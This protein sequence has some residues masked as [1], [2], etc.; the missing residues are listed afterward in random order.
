MD[1]E[2]KVPENGSE[3][4]EEKTDLSTDQQEPETPNEAVEPQAEEPELEMASDDAPVDPPVNE[5]EPSEPNADAPAIE[6][7]VD[8]IVA[9]EQATPEVAESQTDTPI[10]EQPVNAE[11]ALS[12]QIVNNADHKAH[13]KKLHLAI[14]ALLLVIIVGMV[15]YLLAGKSSSPSNASTI[16]AS[17]QAITDQANKSNTERE[18]DIQA[19]GAGIIGY[20]TNNSDTLPQET[21]SSTNGTTLNLCGAGCTEG[22]TNKASVKLSYYKADNVVFESYSASLKVSNADAVYIVD[23]ATC[24]NNTLAPGNGTKTAAIVYGLQQDA[25]ISNVLQQCKQVSLST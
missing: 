4:D 3:S 13:N 22:T 8:A 17:P 19:I 1:S 21:N 23:E 11:P 10:N 24:A 18:N 25:N 6:P 5:V 2:P 20:Q 7:H 15:I 14:I 16:S 12:P 9:N